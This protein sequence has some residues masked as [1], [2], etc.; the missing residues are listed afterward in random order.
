MTQNHSAKLESLHP[1]WAA[2]Q[3]QKQL[4]LS[5]APAGSKIVFNDNGQ[6]EALRLQSAAAQPA[7][8]VKRPHS[9]SHS[10][11]TTD[12]SRSLHPSWAAKRAAAAAAQQAKSMAPQRAQK[13]VFD[14]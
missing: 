8:S 2:K 6:S 10:L 1:S 5:A 14:D 13:V 12:E 3:Q 9:S 4:L 11:P 7:P